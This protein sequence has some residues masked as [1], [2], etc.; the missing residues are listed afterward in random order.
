[1]C[2]GAIRALA[3]SHANQERPFRTHT[4]RGTGKR[5]LPIS[6]FPPQGADGMDEA[7]T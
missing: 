6:G 5:A 7:R 3:A 4:E 1:M 2:A